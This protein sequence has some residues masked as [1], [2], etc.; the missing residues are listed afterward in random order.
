MGRENAL[1]SLQMRGPGCNDEPSENILA[2]PADIQLHHNYEEKMKRHPELENPR[3]TK[4]LS[5]FEVDLQHQR[6]ITKMV[7]CAV[8]GCFTGYD[9]TMKRASE[10]E[11]KYQLFG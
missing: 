4:K 3:K 11:E 9:K 8:V 6:I 7:G 5:P 10:K 1:P 2:R